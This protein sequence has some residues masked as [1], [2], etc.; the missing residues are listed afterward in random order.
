MRTRLILSFLLAL[1]F[2]ACG[3]ES[4]APAATVEPS[5][6]EPSTEEPAGDP[7]PE[8]REPVTPDERPSLAIDVARSSVEF[9]GRKITGSHEGHFNEWS[10]TVRLGDAIVDTRVEIEI[11]MASVETDAERLTTHLKSDEFFDVEQFPTARFSTTTIVEAAGEGGTT[12]RVTGRLTL[13]G[14]SRAITFPATIRLTDDELS[15]EASFTIDRQ[16]FGIAYPGMPDDLIQDQ[17]EIRFNVHAPR[18]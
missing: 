9:T 10:G 18:G 11:Q 13:H 2:T 7:T 6:E 1:A 15:A 3:E 4:S 17:V 8:P 14:V 12:H 5:T 16:Q